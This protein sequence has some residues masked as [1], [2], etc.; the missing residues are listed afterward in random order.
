MP[1]ARRKARGSTQ[2]LGY[3]E[4][5]HTDQANMTVGDAIYSWPDLLWTGLRVG[6]PAVSDGGLS[7]LYDFISQADAA[8][9]RVD[10][11]PVHY[12]RCYG[13][14]GDAAGTANQFYN[15]LK[16]IYDTVKRP[17]WVTEWNNGANWTSC[18]A[19]RS[20]VPSSWMTI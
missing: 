12:Y 19:S 15:H 3:N 16:G 8:G 13:N 10:F 11:V 18:A 7:W 6:A 9:L 2:L 5:D 4:P 1:P 20:A 14:A 17:L